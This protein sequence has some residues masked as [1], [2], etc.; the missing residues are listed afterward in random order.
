MD[1]INHEH[2]CSFDPH[3]KTALLV[4]SLQ[5]RLVLCNFELLYVP[6]PAFNKGKI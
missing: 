6:S 3:K 5:R 1:F 2:F 4:F